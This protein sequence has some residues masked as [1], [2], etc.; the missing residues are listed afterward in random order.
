MFDIMSQAKNAMESYSTKLKSISSNISSMNVSSYKRIEMSFQTVFNQQL[1]G[2]SSAYSAGNEGGTNG[3]QLGG[4]VSISATTI[5]FS[6]GGDIP[7]KNLSLKINNG[8]KFFIVSPDEG[9]SFFY[10]KSGD[11]KISDNK[12]LT[13][14]NMQVYGFSVQDNGMS[15]QQLVPIDISN[16]PGINEADKTK[17][18][19]DTNGRLRMSLDVETDGEEAKYGSPL[20]FQIALSS[21]KNTSGLLMTDGLTYYP[22]ISS[23]PADVPSAPKAGEVVPRSLEASN[24][25]YPSEVVDSLEIQR[26]IDAAMSVIKMAND[27]I[28]AFI[29]KLG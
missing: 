12:L 11:F 10:A 7:G 13:Q 27:S 3:I 2:G 8:D 16:I 15:T 18:T 6:T 4:T 22:T 20:P 5:D 25:D 9:K 21:F 19:W 24:V 23:G 1:S 28:T 29:N 17:I 26:A 14:N